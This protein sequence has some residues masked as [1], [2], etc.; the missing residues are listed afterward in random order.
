VPILN[1]YLDSS[2]DYQKVFGIEIILKFFHIKFEEK[3]IKVDLDIKLN[4]PLPI[5]EKL[6]AH[7]KYA[8]YKISV[9]AMFIIQ[10]YSPKDFINDLVQKEKE[11]SFKP[12]LD[13]SIDEYIKFICEEKSFWLSDLELEDLFNFIRDKIIYDI[14]IKATQEKD[15]LTIPSIHPIEDNDY[16]Q[17]IKVDEINDYIDY[18]VPELVEHKDDKGSENVSLEDLGILEVE[19]EIFENFDEDNIP[20]IKNLYKRKKGSAEK[21]KTNQTARNLLM[22]NVNK[23]GGFTEQRCVGR[24]G[25]VVGGNSNQVAEL[26]DRED[27]LSEM[28]L[29]KSNN[30]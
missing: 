28:Q 7:L 10:L 9:F 30:F 16:D 15:L 3:F 12:K 13:A 25:V 26:R 11:S 23:H 19:E 22:S 2:D 17:I 4:L 1:F 20:V 14:K 6:F 29:R 8:N 24:E 27:L 18:K 5:W 21:L